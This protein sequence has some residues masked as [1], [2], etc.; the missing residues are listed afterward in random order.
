MFEMSNGAPPLKRSI[1]RVVNNPPFHENHAI[2]DAIASQM[3]AE[4]RDVLRCGGELW[5]VGNR[6]L[7]YQAKL[8]R[9]FGNCELVAGNARFVVL[10][11]VRS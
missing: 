1:D 3:F 11:A 2:C 9:L 7:S 10:R 8:K 5:V 6:H 4:S